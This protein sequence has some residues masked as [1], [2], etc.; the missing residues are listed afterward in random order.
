MQWVREV[1]N[2]LLF[3]YSN[4]GIP[5]PSF[6]AQLTVSVWTFLLAAGFGKNV[7]SKNATKAI[8]KYFKMVKV[9]VVI[10]YT[11]I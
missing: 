7:P 11:L 9:F 6:T 4:L 3:E 1:T 8:I 2:S 5:N 10:T